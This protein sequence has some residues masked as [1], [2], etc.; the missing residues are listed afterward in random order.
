MHAIEQGLELLRKLDRMTRR[1]C[2]GV[3]QRLPHAKY[4]QKRSI[5]LFVDPLGFRMRRT[6]LA[7]KARN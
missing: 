4:R 6:N 7:K 1:L 2:R 5:G 3:R